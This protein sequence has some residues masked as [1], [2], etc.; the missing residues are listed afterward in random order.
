M[1]KVGGGNANLCRVHTSS[2][3]KHIQKKDKVENH[4]K[5]KKKKREKKESN[6][7]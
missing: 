7:N 3:R 6:E 2:Y 1:A 5:Y 4:R